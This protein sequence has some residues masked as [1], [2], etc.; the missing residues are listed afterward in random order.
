MIKELKIHIKKLE[1]MKRYPKRV[2]GIGDF[3]L[4]KR[5][6]VSIVGTRRPLRYTREAVSKL[7]SELASR[8]VVIVSGGAMGVDAVA[9]RGAGAKNTIAVSATGL[10]IRYP[11]VNASLIEEIEKSGLVLSMF[12]DNFK[13]TSWSFVVRNELVVALGDILIVAQADINSGSMRSA[14]YALKMG[15]EIFVLPHRMGDSEGTNTLLKDANAKAIYSIDEFAN[16]FG[17]KADESINRDEF[18][19]FCQ[20]NPTIDEAISK[21]GD[22]VYEEELMGNIIIENGLVYISG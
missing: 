7:A 19:Y 20:R 13:A 4:L 14:E 15:K 9:H 5:P 18:F 2:A 16:R 1:S 17:V 21:F 6:S 11:S 22:R 3:S 12:D 10:N 8:G